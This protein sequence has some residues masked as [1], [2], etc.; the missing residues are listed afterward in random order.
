MLRERRGFCSLILV[1]VGVD[2]VVS[3]KTE[4]EKVVYWFYLL[5]SLDKKALYNMNK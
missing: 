1:I 4:N 3:F 2:R 5:G